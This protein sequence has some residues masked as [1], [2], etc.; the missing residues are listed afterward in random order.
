MD[1]GHGDFLNW[2]VFNG[3]IGFLIELV[4]G[5]SRDCRY[6]QNQK[7]IG[8]FLHEESVLRYNVLT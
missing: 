1:D 2:F 8:F 3:L 7:K 4:S 6:S 5:H